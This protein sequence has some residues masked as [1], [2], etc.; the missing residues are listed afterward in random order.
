MPTNLWQPGVSGN[1]AGRL[2]GSRNALS[3]E[4]ISALLRDFRQHGQ[5]A[6]ARVRRT[7][8][9][10]YLKILAL[11]VPREMKI[12][13]AGAIKA[14]SDEQLEAGIEAIQR[15][16]ET[17]S[18][19]DRTKVIEGTAETVALPA[20]DSDDKPKPPNKVMD[21]ADTALGPK[22][23]KP[24]KVPS[25]AKHLISQCW[26]R[27]AAGAGMPTQVRPRRML[28]LCGTQVADAARHK[29]QGC[30]EVCTVQ[31]KRIMFLVSLNGAEF[32]MRNQRR[33]ASPPN[34]VNCTVR[35][36]LT[37]REI[38]KLMDYARK[39]SRYGHRDSTMILVTYRH[40]L[41]ASEVCDL[42]WHQ[43][44]LDQGRMHVRRAKNGTP[45]VH[46]IRGD[47]IC[48][49]RK[50]RRESP[51]E[52]YVFVTERGGPM[53]TIGFHHLIQRLGKAAKMPFSLHPHMLRHACGYK[54]AND[55]HDT[56]AL[57]HY[58]GHKNIQHTV[59]YTEL[60]PDR[61]RDFWRD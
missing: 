35:K 54:L 10:A 36:Y 45:S 11:L 3:E 18:L 48:A 9:A 42:Q 49:L 61:F 17:R 4:V 51:T 46:P 57:Q 27:H 23:R 50:L 34:T 38:E 6:V 12:E 1:P 56:R 20:P 40:G 53:S 44:E 21:A 37:A 15:M 13:H 29:P 8:P 47:E 52:A 5:K 59:R 14:M 24:S 60:S 39:H 26:L 7:Q 43:V 30:D 16:L 32:P 55:G 31:N 2:R 33:N 22:E 25:P 41:R 19:D 28:G 58:L